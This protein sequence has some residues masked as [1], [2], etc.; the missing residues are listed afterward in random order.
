MT[1]HWLS[2]GSSLLTIGCLLCLASDALPAPKPDET[3]AKEDEWGFRPADD[4]TVS[5]NPP[6]FAWRPQ[7]DAAS[8]IWQCARVTDFSHVDFER[9]GIEL[10]VYCPNFGLQPGTWYWRFAF[11][12]TG[13]EQSEFSSVRKFSIPK[14]AVAF[15]RP[16]DEELLARIPQH[17]RL[18]LRPEDLDGLRRKARGPLRSRYEAL[19]KHCEAFLANPP[20]AA[21]PPLYPENL[22]RGSAAWQ[23]IWWGNRERVIAVGDA[24]ATLAFVYL[25]SG[26]ARFA[27][28]ARRLLLAMCSWDPEGSTSFR[29]NDEAAM[30]AAYL[31]AR[32][33]TWLHGYLSEE[34]RATVREV[35]TARGAQIYDNLRRRTHTWRP[36]S[37]HANRAWHK[38]GEVGIALYGEMPEA[39]AWVTYAMNVFYTVYPVWSDEDGGWHEGASYWDD[40]LDRV[41]WWLDVMRATFGI[42]GYQLPFF[43]SA[44]DF[45]LYV[46]PPGMEDGGFADLSEGTRAARLQPLMAVFA[47]HAGNPYWQWYVE[48]VGRLESLDP[49]APGYMR[50]E[51]DADGYIG[52]L[53]ATLPK[54]APKAPTDLRPSKLFAG[55][56]IAVFHTDM[57]DRSRDVQFEFKSSRFGGHSHGYEAQNSFL[58]AAWGKPLLIRT[59][60][61]DGYGSAH[62]RNWM[63][64]TRSVNC[65]LVNG[66]G[67]RPHSF[68]ARGEITDFDAS[69]AFDYVVG[70]AAEAYE[71]RLTRFTRSVLFVK[72]EA[73]L[74]WDELHAPE[75]A[76]YQWLLHAPTEFSIGQNTATATNGA[77]AVQVTW[78]TPGGLRISQTNQFDPPPGGRELVQ[79]HL[80]AATGEPAAQMH[81]VT[82]LQ[83]YRT[84]DAA[85]PAPTLAQAGEAFAVDLPVDQGRATVLLNPTGEKVAHGDLEAAGRVAAVR[86]DTAGTPKAVFAAAAGRVGLKGED[87]GKPEGGAEGKASAKPE[88]KPEAPQ[89]GD[90]AGK[91]QSKAKPKPKPAGRGDAQPRKSP[92]EPEKR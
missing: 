87:E 88:A 46:V 90:A 65:I 47:R 57:L 68:A 86:L 54:P 53:R 52:F 37:S 42:D 12:S 21:E 6:P 13:G 27:A 82:V 15:P 80:T 76:T 81:F 34:D 74:I 78:L 39:G 43:H 36:Y 4:E 14:G 85:P 89:K 62:H 16:T 58:L 48:R 26:E 77:A 73:I 44:G 23:R 31:P 18:F 19:V 20:D 10:N 8:Y 24:A 45:A 92:L 79:W 51:G 50:R 60:R 64:E 69:E 38:L 30:P 5:R 9:R 17:P 67:Q 71:G 33:Y 91:A 63:W 55:T 29:Y 83:P 35:L 59:G 41:A 75:P 22:E 11:V 7:Q 3:P 72:P 49:H 66:Q 84:E 40:Y 28:E 2:I 25:L 61:R 56:G 1:S 32:T 70:E